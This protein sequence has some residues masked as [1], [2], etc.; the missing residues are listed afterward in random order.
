MNNDNTRPDF[1]KR[2]FWDYD[3]DRIDW[4]RDAAGIIE[5]VVERGTHEEWEE[6]ILFYGKFKVVQS[7]KSEIR[8]LPDEIITDVCQFFKLQPEDLL[9]YI[10]KQSHPGH[11]L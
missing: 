1:K 8:F 5:R 2:L 6:L 10:R 9:C 7:L 4:Q 11:W 3:Y